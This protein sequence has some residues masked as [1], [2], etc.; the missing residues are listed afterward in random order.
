MCGGRLGLGGVSPAAADLGWGVKPEVSC[1]RLAG[2]VVKR[3]C[4]GPPRRL[5]G[6]LAQGVAANDGPWHPPR[7]DQAVMPHMTSSR[8]DH[9]YCRWAA[10]VASRAADGSTT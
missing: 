9:S 5:A 2:Y 10:I 8:Q 6:C 7:L 3:S 4:R 1:I